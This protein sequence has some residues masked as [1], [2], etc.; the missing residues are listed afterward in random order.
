MADTLTADGIATWN[1]EY[2]RLGEAGGGWL[3][4][5]LDVGSAVDHLRALA[6]EHDL[7]L[8][9]VVLVGHSAGGYLAM[10]AAAR[11]RIPATSMLH[12]TDPLAVRGVVNLAGSLDISAN[13][14]GYH[15]ECGDTVITSMLGGTPETVPE[16]YARASPLKLLPLRIPQVIV[17]G[18]HE[19]FVPLPLAQA[20]TRAATRAGD[21]VR[22]V[23]IPAVGHFEIASPRTS[24]WPDVA[25]AIRALLDGRLP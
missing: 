20:Y 14:P 13:I 18:A 10:W 23:V 15:A 17:L 25:A 7:D 21:S 16:H 5:Y 24:A 6:R 4:T 2:R 8:N 12:T 1:I 11:S 22:L 9:R 3:G 19:D